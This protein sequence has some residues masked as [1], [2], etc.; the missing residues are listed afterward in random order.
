MKDA[1]RQ[2]TELGDV[3]AALALNHQNLATRK[4]LEGLDRMGPL[5]PL[6][7]ALAPLVVGGGEGI[8]DGGAFTIKGCTKE[9]IDTD[10]LRAA[11][12][13]AALAPELQAATVDVKVDAC[14]FTLAIALTSPTSPAVPRLPAPASVG[15]PR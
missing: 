7:V 8:L 9:G 15:G 4:A 12:G 11:L 14:K 13:A 1:R 10:G 2:C 5:R 3:F 6:F